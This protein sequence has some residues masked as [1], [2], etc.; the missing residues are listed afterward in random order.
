MQGAGLGPSALRNSLL[1]KIPVF[2]WAADWQLRVTSITGAALLPAGIDAHAALGQPVGALFKT[3]E[4]LC[5]HEAVL[6]GTGG[7][8]CVERTHAGMSGGEGSPVGVA[9]VALDITERLVAE[10]ALRLSEQGYHLRGDAKRSAP[11]GQS[12]H[13]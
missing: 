3:K 1:A 2:L 8:F 13:A 7:V 11:A 9:G 4:S 12:G 5:A 6:T 10:T